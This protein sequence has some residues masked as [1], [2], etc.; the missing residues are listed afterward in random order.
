MFRNPIIERE[1]IV[2]DNSSADKTREIVG[3]LQKIH[4]ELKLIE[5]TERSKISGIKK[6][7]NA[8]SERSDAIFFLDGDVVAKRNTLRKLHECLERNREVCIA[9]GR[10]LEVP[11]M[12]QARIEETKKLRY[13]KSV[14]GRIW[15]KARTKEPR[16][17]GISGQIYA[18][19]RRVIDV[20][21][22]IPNNIAREDFYITLKLGNCPRVK[23]VREAIVYHV[24]KTERELMQSEART[25]RLGRMQLEEIFPKREVRRIERERYKKGFELHKLSFWELLHFP[26]FRAY[27]GIQRYRAE[28]KARKIFKR[29]KIDGTYPKFQKAR[30]RRVIK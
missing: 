3:E 25:I 2:C 18:V 29:G 6:I 15:V 7:L 17:A 8:M 13:P 5:S 10:V 22:S 23:T 21:R 30:K 14:F 19:K 9:S 27:L 26:L 4:P 24:A 11:Y 1:V 12:K 16:A 28:R 20:V